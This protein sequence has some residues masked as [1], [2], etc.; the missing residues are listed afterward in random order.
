M[1]I[2]LVLVLAVG[3]WALRSRR[4]AGSMQGATAYGQ[5]LRL[6]LGDREMVER[7]IGFERERDPAA[8]RARLIRRAIARWRQ[9]NR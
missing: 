6:A 8:S 9:D 1:L 2:L 7:L 4:R 3:M 5:L